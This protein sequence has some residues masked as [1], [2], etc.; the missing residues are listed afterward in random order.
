METMT[1]T[2]KVA[3]AYEYCRIVTQRAA[4]TFYL[5]SRLL[6]P[7]KRMAVWALY[8]FCR[9][10]DD[11]VDVASSTTP[12]A[13]QATLDIW[14]D[15]LRLAYRGIGTDL[16][17]LA[18]VDMLQRFDVP[19]RPAMDLIDGVQMDIAGSVRMRTLNELLVYC[20]RVAGT[21][22]LLMSPILGY[23]HEDALPHAVELGIAMQLTNILRDVG[24]DARCNRIYLPSEELERFGYSETELLNGVINDR[25]IALMQFQIARAHDY[26]KQ[27]RPGI[28]LLNKSVQFA[29]TASAELYHGILPSIEAHQYDV[30]S[31]RAHMTT[32][33]KCAALPRIWATARYHRSHICD[34]HRLPES[35]AIVQQQLSI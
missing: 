2:A 23:V 11:A 35:Y 24:E 27:A 34:G 21:V 22:G 3:Q 19:F 26:Y 17:S 6:P 16:I 8:G 1:R 15:R 31:Q 25:F 5:G 30:F 18:W 13:M 14:R 20:Y 32:I 4:K 33:Q 12:A 10:I 9:S 28:A 7:A 29:I